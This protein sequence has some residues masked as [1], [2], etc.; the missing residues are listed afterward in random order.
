MVADEPG[1][2]AEAAADVE[3][4]V[5]RPGGAHHVDGPAQAI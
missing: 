2:A 4:P 1:E 3:E 5:D